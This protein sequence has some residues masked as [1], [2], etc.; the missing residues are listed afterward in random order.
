MFASLIAYVGKRHQALCDT[1]LVVETHEDERLKDFPV[2]LGKFPDGRFQFGG[3]LPLALFVTEVA[4]SLSRH[5]LR[6][7]EESGE[8]PASLGGPR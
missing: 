2:H 7:P 3:S 4:N 8:V 6:C 5:D 1:R